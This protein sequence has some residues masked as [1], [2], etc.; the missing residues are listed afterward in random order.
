MRVAIALILGW[1]MTAFSQ[2][3]PPQPPRIITSA[4]ADS[5]RDGIPDECDSCPR[6]IYEPGFDRRKCAPMDLDPSN[7]SQAE[8]KAR[9]RVARLIFDSGVF[10]TRI[11]FAVVKDGEVHFADA[12]EYIGNNQFRHDPDGVNRLY[13]V[14]STSKP[15]TAVA[16]KLLEE[17]GILSLDDFVNDDDA[18]QY[19]TSFPR[20]V[21]AFEPGDRTLRH[22]LTHDGAFKLDVGAIHLYCY[23][24]SLLGFWLDPDDLVSPHYFGSPYGNLGGGFEYSAF[25][26]SLAGAHLERRT[27][28]T[29]EEILQTL[30][31]D[32]ANMCTA[33]LDGTRAVNTPIGNVPGTAQGPSMHV[34]PYIN[35][36]APN[37]ERCVDNFYSSD[38]LYG[39]N[40]TWQTYHLDECA[41]PARDP[42]GGVIAS[43]IDMAHFAS[44]LLE[45]YRTP[46]G[47]ISQAGVRELW[48]A[49]YDYG[50][51]QDCPYE[52][53]YATGFFTDSL[54]GQPVNQV[55][56]GG[57]RPGFASGFVV[58]PEDNMAVTI[59]ANAD[60]S[61]VTLSDLAK[62]ILDDL[63]R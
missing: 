41:A 43:V 33:T 5:D 4:P 63:G 60:V 46:D 14:G 2:I 42:A 7:D 48:A 53:Y 36:V 59:L 23:N 61:T 30:I 10:V 29:Y 62:T 37:D 35:L 32:R 6:V 15:F 16:A 40:Y 38:A 3:A 21:Q 24:G 34:G 13:R 28:E 54:P 27:Q 18:A 45:S 57:S 49:T 52:R 50:C 12:F 31:F 11:A 8:C 17:R 39:E 47:I 55:G 25:N 51:N 26:Y 58:R 9:E 20:A 1:T 22:L 44:A 19:T 56:H